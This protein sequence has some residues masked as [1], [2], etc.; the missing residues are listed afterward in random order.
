MKT[1][2]NLFAVCLTLA[3]LGLPMHRS[4]AQ[5]N[6]GP[7]QVGNCNASQ[8]ANCDGS[9]DQ[10]QLEAVGS[11]GAQ[12][13]NWHDLSGGVSAR[14]F[15]KRLALI[16]DGI[17]TILL[18]N[19]T[20]SSSLSNVPGSIGVTI[21]PFNLC[22]S[23]ESP[24]NPSDNCYSAP[25]RIGVTVVYR[26]SSG[27]VGSNLSFPNDGDQGTTTGN[28]VTTRTFDG[29]QA[30]TLNSSTIIDLTL[31]LNTLGQS[32]RWTWANGVPTFWDF[33]SLGQANAT[34]RIKFRPAVQPAL[35]YPTLPQTAFLCTA[36]PVTSCDLNQSSSDWLGANLVLSLD[37]TLS[38]SMTGALFAT[39]G[40]IIGSLDVATD[41]STG[42]P[43][44]TYGISS[45]HT[46]YTGT[47]RV[48]TL[49]AFVPVAG[50]VQGLGLPVTQTS[51]GEVQIPLSTILVSRTDSA[52]QP[53]P[54]ITQ[55]RAAT[56][57]EDG[58]LISLDTTFSAPQIRVRGEAGAT[59]SPT[60]KLSKNKYSFTYKATA[61]GA[62]KDCKSKKCTVTVYR[63]SS[64]VLDAKIT[65]VASAVGK[66]SKDSF[67]AALLIKKRATVTK[68]TKLLAVVTNSKKQILSSLPMELTK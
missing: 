2:P 47:V 44:F 15:V 9:P 31:G 3:V 26:K 51:T 7:T 53:T 28:A 68:G 67:S 30:V 4:L 16:N 49:R 39:E 33:E 1:F 25:N 5:S 36:V 10:D 29:S 6:P 32:L 27:Q 52:T 12:N 55:W 14:P 60:V 13:G 65:K 64:E 20:T 17:E 58:A 19:G 8:F 48:G 54:T 46:D 42:L 11:S 38:E 37:T 63:K 34:V 40:A 35:H 62:L 59:K 56:E 41:Q 24:S 21:S 45:S 57:G 61:S 22:D 23:T 50:L 43:R 66:T 18:D